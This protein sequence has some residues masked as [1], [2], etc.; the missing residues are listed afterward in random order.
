MFGREFVNEGE[1]RR[2]HL[3]RVGAW[4]AAAAV[5]G[6]LAVALPGAGGAT[7]SA[8]TG[9]ATATAQSNLRFASP[10][11]GLDGEFVGLSSRADVLA[12]RKNIGPGASI[13]KHYQGI[14]RKDAPDG[15]PYL[16]ITKS[17]NS[18]VCPT[19]E[20]NGVLFVVKMGSRAKY[21]ERLKR[22]LYPYASPAGIVLPFD[23]AIIPAEDRVVAVVP[24]DGQDG[25][26]H[27]RHPGGMQLVDDVLAIGTEVP[28]LASH[29][30][31]T[32]LFFD[33]SNPEEPKFIRKFDPPDLDGTENA[34]FGADPVGLT[35]VKDANGK[36]CRY[37]LVSAGGPGEGGDDLGNAEVRFYLSDLDPGLAKLKDPTVANYAWTEVGRFSEAQIEACNPG[38]NW[39][40][41]IPTQH[42]MLNF[43]REGNLDGR[44]YLYAG[45]RDGSVANPLADEDEYIDLWRVHLQPG[46]LPTGCPLDFVNQKR[47]GLAGLG[48]ALQG[49]GDNI[50]NGSFAAGS[51][52]HVT[53]SGE[54]LV[55]V[56]DHRTTIFGEYRRLGLVRDSSPTMRPTAR[57][58]G[59]FAVDEGS[60]VQLTGQAEA[61]ITKAYVQLFEQ[62]RAGIAHTTAPRLN[63]EYDERGVDH[64]DDLCKLNLGNNG[65]FDPCGD[66]F[67]DPLSDEI[68][69]LRWFAPP[70]CN[71]Q[72]NNYPTRSD[73]FPGPG[74]VILRGTGQ[75]ETVEDLAELRVTAA[76]AGAQPPWAVTPPTDGAGTVYDY[77][78]TIEGVTFY[79]AYRADGALV[80]RHGCQSY[81]NKTFS[82][83]WDLDENGSFEAGGTAVPFSAAALDGPSVS[84]VR[85]RATHPTDTSPTGVGAAMTVPVT[86]RNVAPLIGTASV[87]DP[88]G[89]ELAGGSRFAIAGV[90]LTLAVTFSDPGRADTQ[91]A[92]VDWGDGTPLDTA[93]RSFSG[94]T[95]GATGGLVDKHAFTVPGTHTI[96][97]TITDDDLDATPVELTVTVLSL[98]DAIESL[99]E[100]L[101]QLIAAATDP[102]V[103]SALHAAREELIGNHTGKPPTNG[104]LDKLED[105]DPV[106]A[107]TKLKAAIASLVTA[108]ARGAGDLTALKD[109]IGLVAEGIATAAYSDAEQAVDPPSAGE[110]RALASIAQLIAAGDQQLASHQYATACETFRQASQKAL[111]LT[112]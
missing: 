87:K 7:T 34:A 84:T 8:S 3:R 25:R 57:I 33:V 104:A 43:V 39:P 10:I 37:V 47:V 22:N 59:P 102:R 103:A 69:S 23:P 92:T 16:F 40:T 56:T 71:I 24:L 112:K 80:R 83:G 76:G 53:P 30:R 12:F 101:T 89:Y 42:Q 31:A 54:V 15:T 20:E 86:V 32:V 48:P 55:Y 58:G 72:A 17:G 82:L 94:A 11:E 109:M 68:T 100:Q 78:N 60:T 19:D 18:S 105:E 77:D 49:W 107:I 85:S 45:W 4:A 99:A 14:A 26:P 61:P 111:D 75:I 66:V 88:L 51:G 29:S 64:F 98:E 2:G 108:E 70:G 91:T 74:T 46:G 62:R 93:F 44:L 95:N 36:C 38:F 106:D 110:A 27:Y 67:P 35:P 63:V 28:A 1:K 65:V 21:G 90:P 9:T 5:A 79:E 97:A 73:E 13:C 50:D 96:R 41:G 81:Y 6:C 52:V